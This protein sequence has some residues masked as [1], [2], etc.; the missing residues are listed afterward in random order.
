MFIL[1]QH[2]GSVSSQGWVWVERILGEA[3]EVLA[4]FW[5]RTIFFFL[6]LPLVDIW[7]FKTWGL[8]KIITVIAT[9][10]P[11]HFEVSKVVQCLIAELID[12]M[13]WASTKP[14]GLAFAG[15]K[16]ENLVWF[17]ITLKNDFQM[18]PGFSRAGQG[19]GAKGSVPVGCSASA[20]MPLQGGKT[21][22]PI[23]Y[24]KRSLKME[25]E[26]GRRVS[27]PLSLRPEPG[28]F[29]WRKLLPAL[30]LH[31]SHRQCGCRRE[32]LGAGCPVPS[33]PQTGP[34]RWWLR[35]QSI[36]QF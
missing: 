18:S 33:G 7:I 34:Q 8:F 10:C 31:A 11:S 24:C 13:L 27:L 14:S 19:Y 28:S 3:S 5:H 16:K 20:S 21:Y 23:I 17:A 12:V 25:A 30:W 22:S 9:T 6:F 32:A 1:K 29:I 35:A 4:V 2:S 36:S 15:V 26:G